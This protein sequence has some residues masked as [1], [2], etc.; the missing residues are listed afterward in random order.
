MK[1]ESCHR[2]ECAPAL[3]GGLVRCG[4]CG[5]SGP[6][7]RTAEE[8]VAGWNAEMKVRNDVYFIGSVG[9]G[10]W[11]RGT[12]RAKTYEDLVEDGGP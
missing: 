4:G 1:A 6:V 3:D 11:I 5:L 8:A 2:A 10:Y 7:G 9:S 12:R